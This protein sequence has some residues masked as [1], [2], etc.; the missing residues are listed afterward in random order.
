MF[1]QQAK[2]RLNLHLISSRSRIRDRLKAVFSNKKPPLVICASGG[3]VCCLVLC[4]RIP[5]RHDRV[6][7]A[8]SYADAR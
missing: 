5:L 3:L 8:Y 4:W 6:D 7:D 2:M 1:C